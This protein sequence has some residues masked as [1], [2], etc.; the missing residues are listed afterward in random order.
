MKTERGEGV[1]EE[2]AKASRG[3]FLKFK[4]G[5]DLHHIKMQGEGAQADA[6]AAVSQKIQL[7]LFTKGLP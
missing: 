4:E 1:A 7:R 6:E 3:Q 2:K 5:S